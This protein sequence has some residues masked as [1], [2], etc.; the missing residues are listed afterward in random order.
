MRVEFSVPFVAAQ[1]RPRFRVA[2]AHAQAYKD[3]RDREAEARIAAAFDASAGSYDPPL[4]PRGVPVAVRVDVLRALPKSRPKR[5]ASEPDTARPDA[6]NVS[7][8][9][10]DA[11]NGR[12]WADDSQVTSLT[13]T[14][15]DRVRRRGD[16]TRVSVEIGE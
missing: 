14:K 12:A 10:L 16:E 15:H 11:L 5:V 1:R 8:A 3:R 13:V 2:G 7:K 9:V 4:A 6:D